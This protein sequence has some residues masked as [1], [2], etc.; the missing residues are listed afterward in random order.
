MS[1]FFY[2][3]ILGLFLAFLLIPA[4]QQNSLAQ[5]TTVR[6][7]ELMSDNTTTRA[8]KDGDFSDWIELFNPT[9]SVVSLNGWSLT[10]EL[11][12]P[13]KWVFPAILLQPQQYLL[14]FA[15]GK[16]I[17]TVNSELH[18]NFKLS[19]GG[20]YL[21]LFNS[22]R[23]V[24]TQFSPSL[25]ALDSDISWGYL[26]EG[27]ASFS[28]P[29]PGSANTQAGI[30][31]I[32]VPVFSQQHG[33]YD[34]PFQLALT[35]TTQGAKIYYTTNGST[36]AATNGTL[37]SGPIQISK[38]S[39]IR[40]IAIQS[41]QYKS[42]S[43]TQT[44]LFVDDIIH[45]PNNPAG[46]PD[47]WGKLNSG[48]GNAIADYEIDPEMVADPAFAGRL[49]SALKYLP[50][51]SLVTDKDNFFSQ[52]KD[53]KTGG[54][55]IYTGLDSKP[56]AGYGWE[57]PVSAEYFKS[58]GAP[59][60]QINCGIEIQGGMGRSAE[61]S[62]KHSFRLM[63]KNEYGSGK[64]KFPLF[65]PDAEDEFD[66]LVLRAGY[67]NTWF[68]RY[69]E[70]R[71]S[72]HNS[73]DAWSKDTQLEMGHPSSHGNFV[74]LF[75]NGIYW[76]IY[77]PSE[78]IDAD[79]AASYLDGKSEDFDV[80]KDYG[81][82]IDGNDTAWKNLIRLANAGVEE[83]E[84]YL[85]I[86]GKKPDGTINPEIESLVDVENLIDYMLINFYGGNTDWDYHNWAAI[87]NRIN[88]G[89]GFKFIC[90]DEEQVLKSVD[91]NNISTNNPE[92]PSNIFQQLMK[93]DDFKRL[94][95]DRVAKQCFGNGVLTPQATAER[96]M[97]RS[98][99]LEDAIDAE[100]ARWGDYR[101]DVHQF[102][103][104]PYELY[105]KEDHWLPER[106]KLI[107]NYFPQRTN[108]FLAQLKEKGFYPT[109]VAPVFKLN[110]NTVLQRII[111][112]GDQ[113]TMT[114]TGGTIYY[115]VNGTDPV[116]WHPQ[117]GATGG[118]IAVGAIK[119]TGD[120]N[121]NHSSHIKARTFLN[122][123]WSAASE[124]L[125]SIPEELH[126][127]KITEINYHPADTDTNE[128]GD[129]E[130]IEIKNTGGS[131]VDMSG[132]K[133]IHG[134][135][136]V[137]PD[138]AS[139]KPGGFI[140]LAS[141]QLAFYYRYGF[142]PFDD[143]KDNFEN[144][145][146]WVVLAS[147]SNDTLCSFIYSDASNWPDLTDGEGFTL[148]S[149]DLNPENDQTLPGYWRTS[150]KPGGSPGA[151]DIIPVDVKALDRSTV[152]NGFSLR[153]NYPN[154]FSENTSIDF[155][156]SEPA[157]VKL[158]VYNITGQVVAVLTNRK[159][160]SGLHQISWAPGETQNQV[161]SEGVYFY[162]IEVNSCAYSE[163][164]TRKMMLVK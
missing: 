164:Q 37:Y 48:S 133:F 76:G 35:S 156:L 67:N 120:V 5:N 140:V 127:L 102:Q 121:L 92:A 47:K 72:A 20:E 39:I 124:A 31:E 81:E 153:Q 26:P 136:Y 139:L 43:F 158:T 60:F 21:G 159:Y 154:P 15:S 97:K 66:N 42:N 152:D 163:S 90:W 80:I 41:G 85:N 162:R 32:P 118:V 142:M 109:V 63:F 70:Q 128:Y 2:R 22:S 157:Q 27:W 131:N 78:R 65:G 129:P 24:V 45:Q 38:T 100:S 115:S 94:F 6:I 11:A 160:Q 103:N 137:F 135:D 106:E 87:R 113:L 116:D 119:Y 149:A 46:Y 51:V 79:F 16:D 19:A 111:S 95:A 17:K 108:I 104:G 3:T 114:S 44:Y 29:T 151:D 61:N 84:D 145:R 77:N 150:H 56:D 134:I 71:Q 9:S 28:D 83:T 132:V 34:S 53:E 82:V 55:Y 75:I 138:G 57:R 107:S 8:D 40:A 54:I 68:H 25:P 130:F 86:Q 12:V 126:S 98:L 123:K 59:S 112:S 1:Y 143:Y 125:F 7:N 30:S 99:F 146:E 58:D 117:S 73:R 4:F 69:A 10:D 122:G 14:V 147:A 155:T 91:Q 141:D 23:Q 93:N 161:L 64:L 144:S 33:F 74:H 88:P 50:V 89:K 62:P 49:K 13:G 110:G 96:F 105:T 36:P 148:V 52:V 18:T 101:R